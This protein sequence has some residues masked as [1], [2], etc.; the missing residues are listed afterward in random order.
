VHIVSTIVFSRHP[1]RT[2]SVIDL[3]DCDGS[4]KDVQERRREAAQPRR[5]FYLREQP[6]KVMPRGRAD[7]KCGVKQGKVS[8][9]VNEVSDLPDSSHLKSHSVIVMSDSMVAH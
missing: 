7:K 6:A 5:I 4:E 8:D 3:Q 1:C 9:F 2:R